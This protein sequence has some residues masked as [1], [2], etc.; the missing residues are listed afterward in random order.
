MTI[1]QLNAAMKNSYV[2]FKADEVA[3]ET[4]RQAIEQFFN[5]HLNPTEE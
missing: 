2:S 4:E 1:E 3:K 5:D